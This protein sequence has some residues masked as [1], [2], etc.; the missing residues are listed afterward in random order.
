MRISDWSSDVCSSDLGQVHVCRSQRQCLAVR[1]DQHVG[2]DRNGIA[3]LHDA[4]YVREGLEERRAFNGQLHDRM[5]CLLRA[6]MLFLSWG[7]GTGPAR[8]LDRK[9]V[10][11]GKGLLVRVYYG[12]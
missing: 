11:E 3:P 8:P 9:R 10:V 2:Q 12:G 4:L 1:L 7:P 5:L 6:L